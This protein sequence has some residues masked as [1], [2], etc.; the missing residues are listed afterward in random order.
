VPVEPAPGGP[1]GGPAD[2]VA[3]RPADPAA[4]GE[5]VPAPGFGTGA[6]GER[7]AP[8]EVTTQETPA[9]DVDAPPAE[10]AGP[11]Q[12]C[13][14]CGEPNAPDAN[15][16]EACGA[17]VD[18][19]PA[20]A[21]TAPAATLVPN[22]QACTQ[23]GGAIDADGYCTSCGMRALEPVA[24]D[25]RGTF[26]YA[27][28]R[29]RRKKRNEDAG[30]LAATAEGYPVLV[31]SDGVSVSPNPHLASAAAV[32]AAAES[33]AGRPFGGA[34]SLIEA[35]RAAHE[36][37][38]DTPAEGDPTWIADGSHPACTIVVA[39]ATDEAVHAANVGDARG[40]LLRAQPDG[41]SW[42]AVQLTSDDSM[43]AVAVREGVDPEIALHAPGGH[44]L[45]RWLGADAPA[46]EVHVA[47]SEA[48]AG[49]VLLVTSDGL[50]NYAATDNLITEVANAM[51]PPVTGSD[52]G[53]TCEVLTTWAIDQG[54]ADNVTVAL[55][56]VALRVAGDQTEREEH[57]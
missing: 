43:A 16:C 50:W 14:A 44:T 30:A 28:H 41:E 12:A 39:V 31:V 17:A 7:L 29:G 45:T 23:C 49:D 56:P 51:V 55:C 25:S 13:P 47:S 48:K 33:L 11:T 46:L 42:K 10:A 9:I 2:P 53:A 19:G 8:A 4:G 22:A 57:P 52:P 27:T 36:A 38:C 6:D 26:A 3:G 18:S 15:F 34:D 1:T 35:V 24:V 40:H 5:P 37:A 21:E 32:A 20:T 54:G